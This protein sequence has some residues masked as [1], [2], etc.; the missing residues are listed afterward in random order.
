MCLQT[1]RKQ[2][3]LCCL[4]DRLE[5]VGINGYDKLHKCVWQ[6]QI[7][8]FK[9]SIHFFF[10]FNLNGKIGCLNFFFACFLKNPQVPVVFVKTLDVSAFSLSPS[11]FQTSWIP[12]GVTGLLE[13]V[14]VTVGRRRPVQGHTL[15]WWPVHCRATQQHT[16]TSTPRNHQSI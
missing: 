2:S 14:S 1:V 8:T 10:T 5:E 16:I 6:I 11:I 3:F 15:H 12:F 9:T 4:D 13:S 7:Q